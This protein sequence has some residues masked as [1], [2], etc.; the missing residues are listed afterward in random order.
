MTTT[1]PE[2]VSTVTTP[3]YI[4]MTAKACM[5]GSCKFGDYR[6]VA[7]IER[8]GDL[9]PSQIHPNHRAVRRIVRVWDRLNNGSTS[10]CAY[11]VALAAARELAVEFNAT[12]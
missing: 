2:I 9:I 5:P 8:E 10:R 1:T 12:I 11:Q 3:R 6:K 4:V 7:V